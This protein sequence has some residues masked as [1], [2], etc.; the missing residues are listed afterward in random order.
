MRG[1]S[2]LSK[3]CCLALEWLALAVWIGGLLILVGGV[4]PAV[5]NIF[6]GQDAGGLFL[7]KVF[8]GYNRFILGAFAAMCAGLCFRWWSG[9]PAVAV[10]RGEA[11]LVAGM[12]T[13]AVVIIVFL[14]PQAA[15]LQAEA[16]LAQGEAERK[17]A[18]EA[19]FQ[20]LMPVRWLYTASLVLGIWLIGVRVKRSLYQDKGL[21]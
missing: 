13:I 11:T 21:T 19:L 7:T 3:V 14:H 5:F 10:G 6:G 8:E 12:G 1:L 20:V 15:T 17:A 4:I 2:G 9:D 16:F 18:F